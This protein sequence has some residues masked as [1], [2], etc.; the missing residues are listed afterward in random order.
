[1]LEL[2]S[3]QNRVPAM[4]DAALNKV[5][6]LEKIVL[7]HPQTN[8]PTIHTLHGNVYTRTIMIP[9]DVVLT[10]ALIKIATTLIICG[11]IT[12]YVG[13]KAICLTGYNVLAASANRKQ[14]FVAHSDTYI[15]M[16]FHTQA[17]TVEEAED[18]FTDDAHLLMS[19]H[20]DALNTFIITGE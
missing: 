15:T 20:D 14:A 19:R 12:V 9:A 10:G 8:I 17:K 1:M 2:V 13:E 16:T 6:A 18:Q 11:D 3:N 7:E 5:R 4:S